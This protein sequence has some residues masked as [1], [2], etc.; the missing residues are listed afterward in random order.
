MKSLLPNVS[1]FRHLILLERRGKTLYLLKQNA[2]PSKQREVR[3]KFP[4]V[5]FADFNAV[6]KTFCCQVMNLDTAAATYY[7]TGA[8]ISF[9]TLFA[10]ELKVTRKNHR[11]TKIYNAR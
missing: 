1:E 3:K 11:F 8:H 6:D 4:A 9:L 7:M 2:K 10:T 5:E